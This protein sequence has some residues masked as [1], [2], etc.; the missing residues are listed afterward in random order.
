MSAEPLEAGGTREFRVLG[1]GSICSSLSFH[2]SYYVLEVLSVQL[3]T[4]RKWLLF[5]PAGFPCWLL[6]KDG[7]VQLGYLY[8]LTW[9]ANSCQAMWEGGKDLVAIRSSAV[10][11]LTKP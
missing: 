9:Y 3:R 1:T 2:H 6:S 4:S 11:A 10:A 5:C 7:I 8:V